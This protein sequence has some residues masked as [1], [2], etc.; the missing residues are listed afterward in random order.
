MS[1]LIWISI[2]IILVLGGLL[3]FI[4][5][6]KRWKES[7]QRELV[8]DALKIMLDQKQQGLQTSASYLG[9]ALNLNPRP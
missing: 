6:F 2:S 3:L 9:G 4:P 8:E 7:R 1:P 5:R